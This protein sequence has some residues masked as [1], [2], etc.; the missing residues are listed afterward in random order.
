MSLERLRTKLIIILVLISSVPLILFAT[1]VYRKEAG[2][3]RIKALSHLESIVAQNTYMIEK[4][5]QERIRDLNLLAA[6]IESRGVEC[7]KAYLKLMHGERTIYKHVF[8]AD[9]QG[10]ITCQTGTEHV[11]KGEMV[12]QTWFKAALRGR[13]FMGE[14]TS[15]EANDRYDLLLAVPLKSANGMISGVAGTIVDFQN[16][17]EIMKGAGI[18]QTGEIYI[19]NKNG[20]FLTSTQVG[21]S[22]AGERMGPELFAEYFKEVGPDEYIDYRGKRVVRVFKKLSDPNWYLVGE[23]DAAEVFKDVTSLRNL[24]AGFVVLLIALITL[25]GYLI[26]TR[27]VRLL[28][29]AYEQKKELEIQLIQKDKL[30][31]MGLLTAGIA[32]ELNTPLASALLYTQMLKEDARNT[33]SAAV[34]KLSSIEAEI[35]RGSKIVRNLLDF[36]RQSQTDSVTTDVNAVLG[37]LLD[38]SEKLCTDRGIEIRR[39]FEKDLPLVKGNASIL[40]QVFMNIVA[41]AVDAMEK[42]GILTVQTRYIDSLHKTVIEIQDTGIGIPEKLLGDVF[43]PFFTTKSSEEGTGLGLAIS[44][45]MVRKMGG[46]IRVTSSFC[47]EGDKPSK[48]TGTTFTIE[49]PALDHDSQETKKERTVE[50]R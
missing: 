33:W 46:N 40:H 1:V 34:E 24:F 27:F 25:I 49:V 39:I 16:I 4:F 50:T 36:S 10:R 3:V 14:G 31:S 19:L 7:D 17:A 29:A 47:S 12:D 41:N 43:D 37:K 2:L 22:R 8:L 38:I 48:P 18:G 11:F 9:K 23:Q 35:K 20:V 13:S 5:R 6:T 32:H 42:G 15:R 44:Y 21:E 30:A 45:S 26:S 28:K